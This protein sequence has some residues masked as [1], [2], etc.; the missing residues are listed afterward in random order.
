MAGSRLLPEQELPARVARLTHSAMIYCAA[1]TTLPDA[2]EHL[3]IVTL[4]DAYEN[5]V[6]DQRRYVIQ[7]P[8]QASGNEDF[9]VRPAETRDGRSSTRANHVHRLRLERPG[10]ALV[11]A[12]TA[13]LCRGALHA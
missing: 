13:R 11:D 4:R 3:A 12:L 9:V 7:V 8:P 5:V 2:A 6:P 1:K 10:G